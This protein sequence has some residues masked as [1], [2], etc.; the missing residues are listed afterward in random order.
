MKKILFAL[1]GVLTL[2]VSCSKDSNLDDYNKRPE[3]ALE[4]A[5]AKL[6]D[7][8]IYSGSTVLKS[9]LVPT[10]TRAGF[11]ASH[12]GLKTDKPT[13]N[14]PINTQLSKVDYNGSRYV[15]Q[16]GGTYTVCE[17][18]KLFANLDVSNATGSVTINV[19][20]G[21]TL[22][23]GGD[24]NGSTNFH[25]NVYPGGK[26]YWGWNE[27]SIGAGVLSIGNGG[28]AQ[29]DCAG[30]VGA[31]KNG[32]YY[33]NNFSEVEIKAGSHLYLYK[34][35]MNYF[36][37][38]G[39]LFWEGNGGEIYSEIPV[40]VNSF[41]TN[42]GK[43]EFMDRF[44]CNGNAD[45]KSGADI[46]FH[47]CSE[48]KGDA[49]L[50]GG[51]TKITVNEYLKINRVSFD[52]NK[53]YLNDALFET[54]NA[55]IYAKGNSGAIVSNG[56][57]ISV[58]KSGEIRFN[59]FVEADPRIESLQ[60]NLVVLCNKDN[61]V[62]GDQY[63]V[64]NSIYNTYEN[65]KLV[66]PVYKDSNVRV[67]PNSNDYYLPA[68]DCRPAQ[69]TDPTPPVTYYW[70]KTGVIAGEGTTTGD[71]DKV[72]S[73]ESRT[74][75]AI[76]AEG[77]EFLQWSD[78]SHDAI[79]TIVIDHNTEMFAS[80]KKIEYT[81]EV[82]VKDGQE[83]WGTV[84]GGGTYEYGTTATYTATPADGYRFVK[85]EEGGTDAT[86]T[87]V[88]KQ[89]EKRTAVFEPVP[90]YDLTV[91]V[92]TGQEDW[93]TVS[94]S[95]TN[96][97]EGESRIFEAVPNEGY[98]FVEW[99]DGDKNPRRTVTMDKDYEFI[100]IFKKT[101]KE[102]D[103]EDP[104]YYEDKG[105]VEVNLSVNDKKDKDDYIWSKLSIHVRDTTDVEIFIPVGAEYYCE[106]DDFY[107]VQKHDKEDAYVYTDN[108]E[109]VEMEIAGQKV[110]LTIEHQ[111]NGMRIT[112]DGIN[113]AVLKECRKTYGDGI[114]FEVYSY[115]NEKITSREMLKG[116]L[117]QTTIKF[118]DEEPDYYINAFGKVR[119]Y[120]APIYSKTVNNVT[121]L[122]TDEA[123]TQILPYQYWERTT[124]GGVN[125]FGHK[126]P[127]DCVVTPIDVAS[128][129]FTTFVEG[130]YN[131]N[132]PQVLETK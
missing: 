64:G 3:K 15:L 78:G 104:I 73:G 97:P 62:K 48:I 111:Q 114:T 79:H 58:F 76:P 51:L 16:D 129:H 44:T 87:V 34:G 39:K 121:T 108:T 23:I 95:E 123:C 31:Y 10:E 110:T 74:V 109:K 128:G 90:T 99:N 93:G 56:N 66:V 120:T 92:T 132:Y 126:N 101:E 105:H 33:D 11:A 37:V 4:I 36:K 77:Y 22:T 41:D 27:Y 80:F 107:I 106:A 18:E 117:D 89:N 122:Y 43:A 61:M 103:P 85:W 96:I 118:L 75:K 30:S 98:E 55:I 46:T 1:L 29:I 70:L 21:A 60:G 45:I 115:Y 25:I 65:G 84:T 24:H 86:G 50:S 6:P 130:E 83:G 116:L 81:L 40:E 127:W 59:S 71:D 53:M 28:T 49:F 102:P 20:S 38:N 94:G 63:Y 88:M 119:E 35:D 17:G 112:T 2:F 68:T 91:L 47:K 124:D 125:I 57:G 100:A 72:P 7:Y 8:H 54:N 9:T 19:A 52:S 26:L 14:C 82:V 12:R 113:S 69:G 67:N 13:G 42:S 32:Q 5:L 131:K